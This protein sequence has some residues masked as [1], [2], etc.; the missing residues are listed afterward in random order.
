MSVNQPETIQELKHEIKVA[1]MKSKLPHEI[2]AHT[3]E[4]I[5]KNWVD[6]MGYCAAS[7]GSHLNEIVFHSMA[8]Y[9]LSNKAINFEKYSCVFF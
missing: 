3:V 5:L 6:R 4:N 7:C 8:M 9:Y 2:R 1:I